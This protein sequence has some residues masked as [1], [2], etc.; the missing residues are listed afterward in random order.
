MRIARF[1]SRSKLAKRYGKDIFELVNE[2]YSELYGFTELSK[3]QIEQYIKMYLP[4]ID[5][6]LA[7]FVIDKD[8]K[9]V[10]M[11]VSIYSLSE[12]L[13]KAKGKL[14]P[15]GWWH[16]AKALFIKPPK[17]LDFLLVAV[18][19]EYQSKGVFAMIFNDL[20]GNFIE[21]GLVDVESNPELE[22]NKKMHSQWDDFDKEQ[23]KRRRAFKK[24]L[25]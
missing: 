18:K 7:S 21:M 11:G 10:A 19:P 13:R 6:R 25:L 15:F 3:K 8:D 17:R 24:E 20:L 9:L 22:D 23:H 4:V 14:F 1:K 16:M 5:L 12:A 2:C